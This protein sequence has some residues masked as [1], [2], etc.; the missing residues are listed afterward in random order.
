[1]TACCL[2]KIIDKFKESGSFEVKC[3]R[4]RKVIAS[5]SVE[6]VATA[7][8]VAS[9]SALR[10]CSAQGISR[11]SDVSVSTVRK[12]LGS[13]LQFYPFKITHIQELVPTDLPKQEAFSLQFLARMEVENAWPWNICGQTKPISISKVLSILKIAEYGKRESVPNATIASSFSKG[14]CVVWVYSSI[15]RWSFL[16]RGDWSFRSCNL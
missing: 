5:T 16:F 2:K 6:D 13:I 3:G 8:Q 4:G 9:S 12:I 7:L 1:M 10:T 11:T 15:Y 14:N